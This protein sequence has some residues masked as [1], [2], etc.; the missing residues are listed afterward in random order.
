MDGRGPV[1]RAFRVPDYRHPAGFKIVGGLFPELLCAA[2]PEDLASLLFRA[3]PDVCDPAA[4]PPA[5][6]ART[7]SA[8]L[9]V[10]VVSIVSAEFSG[11][12][13]G[14]GS[15]AAGGIVVTGGGGTFLPGLAVVRAI[16]Q[17]R[18]VAI[19]C[20]DG[21]SPLAGSSL[22]VSHAPLDHLLQ[23]VLPAGRDDGGRAAG[24]PGAKIQLCAS[25]VIKASVDF[26]SGGRAP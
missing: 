13:A 23:P 3:D 21:A 7:F 19:P 17:E 9:A 6:R 11:G 20:V 10:V 5:G 15:R 16:S 14:A 22:I 24:N 25:A 8:L 18:P 4:G 2:V 26:I 1:L 12:R